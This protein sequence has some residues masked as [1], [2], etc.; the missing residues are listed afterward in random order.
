MPDHPEQRVFVEQRISVDAHQE[1]GRTGHGTGLQRHGL[2]HVPR[3][4]HHAQTLY[5]SNLF[6]QY[7]TGAIGAAIVN[8]N[9]FK[10]RI[11]ILGK[12]R[13]RIVD[14]HF[15]IMAGNQNRNTRVLIQLGHMPLFPFA[16]KIKYDRPHHPEYCHE[17]GIEKDKEKQELHAYLRVSTTVCAMISRAARRSAGRSA[18]GLSFVYP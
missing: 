9:D 11:F 18:P 3:E 1:L 12:L 17:Q 10:I 14:D 4:R 15:L 13:E 16:A 7:L 5:F 8:G 2:A 6:L